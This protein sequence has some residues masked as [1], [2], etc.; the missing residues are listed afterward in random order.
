MGYYILYHTD[1][2]DAKY[3]FYDTISVNALGYSIMA[4]SLDW[5]YLYDEKLKSL[6]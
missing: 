6:G 2:S 3:P 1:L 4:Q 5:N